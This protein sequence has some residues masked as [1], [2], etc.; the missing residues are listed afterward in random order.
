MRAF[1][2]PLHDADTV[3]LDELESELLPTIID[4]RSTRSACP[5][6]STPVKDTLEK[7]LAPRAKEAIKT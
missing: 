7:P 2:D 5:S 6:N 4:L 1:A 3:L